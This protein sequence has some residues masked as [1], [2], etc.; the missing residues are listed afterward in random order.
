MARWVRTVKGIDKET[1]C[2]IVDHLERSTKS[3]HSKWKYPSREDVQ[4]IEDEQIVEIDVIGEW[5]FSAD[6][7]KRLF[8]L[9]N[10]QSICV[11]LKCMLISDLLK[12]LWMLLILKILII[13]PLE[14]TWVSTH[15]LSSPEYPSWFF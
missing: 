3:S 10:A 9:N 12:A 15:S 8:T 7:R 11:L 5:D 1:Q 2:Y 6:S 14:F 13:I 4:V